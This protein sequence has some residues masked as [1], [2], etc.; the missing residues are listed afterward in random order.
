M[1]QQGLHLAG[2]QQRIAIAP[3]VERLDPHRVTRER[4]RALEH[5]VEG[6]SEDAL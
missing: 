3:P 4:Q 6:E 2:E 1:T 5:V